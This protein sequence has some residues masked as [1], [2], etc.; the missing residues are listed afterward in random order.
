MCKGNTAIAVVLE[1]YDTAVEFKIVGK[2]KAFLFLRHKL[3]LLK[4]YLLLLNK[5]FVSYEKRIIGL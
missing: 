4:L 1:V 2:G 3:S 5:T